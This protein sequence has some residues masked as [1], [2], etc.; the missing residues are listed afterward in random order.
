MLYPP[1][2]CKKITKPL[3][4]T[5]KKGNTH[6]PPPPPATKNSTI[7]HPLVSLRIHTSIHLHPSVTCVLHLPTSPVCQHS[8]PFSSPTHHFLSLPLPFFIIRLPFLFLLFVF[9][10]FYLPLRFFLFFFFLLPF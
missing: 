8:Y 5:L 9:S 10:F 1:Q 3:D 6:G 7:T 4:V 2:T